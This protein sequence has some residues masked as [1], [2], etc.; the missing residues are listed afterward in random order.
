M[1]AGVK[2]G[3]ID[4]LWNQYRAAKKA[5]DGAKSAEKDARSELNRLECRTANAA[6]AES[7]AWEALQKAVSR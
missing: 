1:E 4:T 5:L 3:E 2:D 7:K 6:N